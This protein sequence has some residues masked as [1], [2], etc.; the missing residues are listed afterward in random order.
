VTR[1]LLDTHVVLWLLTEP[2]R[3]SR[4]SRELLADLE[5]AVVISSVS[6]YEIA[7]KHQLGR[8]AEA[9]GVVEGY[10]EHLRRLQ[11]EELALT[12]AHALMAARLP[13][14]HRD[15]FDRLLAAQSIVEGLS[16]VT[17]DTALSD[18]GAPTLW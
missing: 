14:P 4:R 15:P 9:Q 12:A 1:V 2:R 17:R 8:L 3:L 18:L 5:T 16:I 7:R 11:A 6:A 10:H 13:G